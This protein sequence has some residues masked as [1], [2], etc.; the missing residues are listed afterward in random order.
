MGYANHAE[1][2]AMD[3]A[4]RSGADISGADIYCAGYFPE[5]HTGFLGRDRLILKDGPWYTCVRC[6]PRMETYGIA[7]IYVPTPNGWAGMSIDEA[8]ECGKRFT[9][10]THE[11]RISSVSTGFTLADIGGS[12]LSPEYL[13]IH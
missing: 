3:D 6:P 4:I 11:K 10:G 5:P 12:L 2:E 7:N 13:H 9:K 1:I 8:D